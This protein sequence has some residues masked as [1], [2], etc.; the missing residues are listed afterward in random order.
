[1]GSRKPRSWPT[2]AQAVTSVLRRN[3]I[4][5]EVV[6]QLGIPDRLYQ[7]NPGSFS[8]SAELAVDPVAV[9]LY[10]GNALPLDAIP[11]YGLALFSHGSNLFCLLVDGTRRIIVFEAIDN[12][13]ARAGACWTLFSRSL[14][15]ATERASSGGGFHFVVSKDGG[16]RLV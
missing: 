15:A 13:Y 6:A 14:A 12:M 2:T 5:D 3:S 11:E 1:M 8:S 16:Q 7:H 4:P 9:S 10:A